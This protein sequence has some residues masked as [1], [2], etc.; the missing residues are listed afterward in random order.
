MRASMAQNTA[1]LPRSTWLLLAILTL[2]WGMNWPM[3]KMGLAD[4][5]VFTFRFLC[6]AAGAAGLFAIARVSGLRIAV[7][8]GEW[9]PLVAMSLC[10]VTLWNILIAYGIQ[11]MPSGRSAILAYTMPLWTVLLSVPI[12]HEKLTRRRLAGITLGMS[13]LALLLAAELTSLRAAP[14]GALL[15]VGAALSWATG[16]TLTKKYRSTLPTTSFTAWNLFLGGIPLAIGAL[17]LEPSQWR[18]IGPSAMVGLV[19]NMIVAFIIC[20]WIWFKIVS[21]APA[22]VSALGTLTIP[23]VAVFSGMLLLGERPKWSD[24]AA[25]ALIVAA[26]A[27]VLVPR[28]ARG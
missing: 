20:H 14:F 1:T 17:L 12:L 26:V 18:P 5:P 27:T 8:R 10:N 25:L 7:P 13:G 9:R 21:L 28:G 24:Y 15:I 3:I 4:I 6:V 2:G 23:V 11:M 22:G 19:Y 16:T